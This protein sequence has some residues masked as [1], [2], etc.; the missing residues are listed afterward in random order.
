MVVGEPGEDGLYVIQTVIS[1]GIV[2]V[3]T[4]YPSMVVRSA[5]ETAV[6]LQ[7]AA[8]WYALVSQVLVI[9]CFVVLSFDAFDKL[10]WVKPAVLTR[11]S[12]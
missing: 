7:H 11:V 5:L 6:K 9:V 2:H 4:L 8:S 12:L 1:I 3:T 10:P